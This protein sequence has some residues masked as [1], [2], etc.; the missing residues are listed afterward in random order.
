MLMRGKKNRTEGDRGWGPFTGRQLT[1]IICV[2]LVTILFPVGAWAVSGSNVFV[3]DIHSGDHAAVNS[4]GQLQTH[5]NGT[6]TVAGSVTAAVSGSVTAT[7]SPPSAMYHEFAGGNVNDCIPIATAPV[8]EATV[9]TSIHVTAGVGISGTVRLA[10]SANCASQTLDFAAM[11]SADGQRDF[12]FPSGLP[13]ANGHH[14]YV[15]VKE[16]SGSPDVGVYSFGYNVPA[17]QC[18]SGCL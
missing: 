15:Q 12:E 4:A 3:T 18:A 10:A 9:L 13:V 16:A 17:A 6:Q 11:S 2:G 7:P 14:L 1:T 8:G 5:P